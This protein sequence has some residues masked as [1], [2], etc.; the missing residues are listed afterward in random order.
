[1]LLRSEAAADSAGPPPAERTL[2]QPRKSGPHAVIRVADSPPSPLAGLSI[3]YSKIRAEL[4]G[5]TGIEPVTSSVS[6]KS[7]DGQTSYDAPLS[8]V[9]A[10]DMQA[11][12]RCGSLAVAG[13]CSPDSPPGR[14][15][16]RHAGTARQWRRRR[17]L[18]GARRPM[19]KQH[20]AP[21]VRGQM[22]RRDH[23]GPETGG[24]LR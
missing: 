20:A 17:H 23:C 16:R 2:M 3:R 7:G 10:A 19:Q 24:R 13:S 5:G 12:S 6:A 11:I 4:V 15:S 8:A 18:L 1:M 9:L 21:P 14:F 22:A